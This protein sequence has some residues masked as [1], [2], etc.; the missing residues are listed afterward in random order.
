M[1]SCDT[2]DFKSALRG[3][4]NLWMHCNNTVREY[5][6]GSGA[7]FVLHMP[8]QDENGSD[9]PASNGTGPGSGIRFIPA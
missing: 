9:A 2:A 1:Q 4:D 5:F 8:M 3:T 7:V 6:Y